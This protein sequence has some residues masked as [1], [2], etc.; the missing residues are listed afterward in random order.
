MLETGKSPLMS[1][2]GWATA[3]I[4]LWNYG[5]SSRP[6]GESTL[7]I[8]V[9]N[10]L[11]FPGPARSAFLS[12][13]R[14]LLRPLTRFCHVAHRRNPIVRA[15]HVKNRIGLRPCRPQPR[16]AKPNRSPGHGRFSEVGRAKIRERP[17]VGT[18]RDPLQALPGP[19]PA[20]SLGPQC[21]P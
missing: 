4:I 21:Y 7:S 9:M 2:T 1:P 10:L 14:R 15:H 18:R 3:A 8:R 5:L 13:I 19:A 6:W 11:Q 17:S 16:V 12:S 20:N